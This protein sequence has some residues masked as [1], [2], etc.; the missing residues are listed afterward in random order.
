[1]GSVF[2]HE[3]FWDYI[4][5]KRLYLQIEILIL[6]EYRKGGLATAP[7]VKRSIADSKEKIN[8]KRKESVR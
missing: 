6:A 5:E 4:P 1:M 3:N 2:T 7:T 8:I